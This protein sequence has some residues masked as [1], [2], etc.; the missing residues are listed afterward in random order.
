[1]FLETYSPPKVTQEETDNLKTQSIRSE[2]E[3]IIYIIS[4]YKNPGADDF[5]GKFSQTYKELL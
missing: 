3:S 1:M 2:I 5:T 4:P